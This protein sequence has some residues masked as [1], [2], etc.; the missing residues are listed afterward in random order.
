MTVM[1]MLAAVVESFIEMNRSLNVAQA[2][3]ELVA[4]C[5]SL[6]TLGVS[7]FLPHPAS[8]LLRVTQ[9]RLSET[10]FFRCHSCPFPSI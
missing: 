1:M 9:Y 4:L 6:L 8:V 3:L 2:G 10:D 5:I 7:H